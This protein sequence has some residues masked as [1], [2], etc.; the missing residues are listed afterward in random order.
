MD[1]A[2]ARLINKFMDE[3]QAYES[4]NGVYCKLF[5]DR[6]CNGGTMSVEIRKQFGE[7]LSKTSL[8]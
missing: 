5:R 8:K 4:V 7:P 3:L 2:L 6:G 1:D